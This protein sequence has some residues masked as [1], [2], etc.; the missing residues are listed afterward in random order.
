MSISNYFVPSN[1]TVNAVLT[2][3]VPRLFVEY[4]HPS[5]PLHMTVNFRVYRPAPTHA[6]AAIYMLM[7]AILFTLHVLRYCER[8][9]IYLAHPQAAL[10][11]PWRSHCIRVSGSCY[12]HMTSRRSRAD[13]RLSA[14]H[15]TAALALS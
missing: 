2:Q 15:S 14:S 13:L 1:E 12:Y 4:V 5:F 10:A 11:P 9:N 7:S 3:L 8:S 6:L